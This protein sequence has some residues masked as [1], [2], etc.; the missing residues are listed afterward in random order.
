MG[1]NYGIGARTETY[2]IEAELKLVNGHFEGKNNTRFEAFEEQTI[3]P[4][5]IF[6]FKGR[7]RSSFSGQLDD[8]GR[9]KR[10]THSHKHLGKVQEP[11]SADIDF[12]FN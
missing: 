2:P 4:K 5:K 11:K 7:E 10:Q 6:C 3:Q 9:G 1:K 8:A 12:F